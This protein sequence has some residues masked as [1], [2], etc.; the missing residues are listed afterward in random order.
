MMKS[1]D[2]TI[3]EKAIAYDEALIMTD[4]TFNK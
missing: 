3:E 1:I 2:M 4:F